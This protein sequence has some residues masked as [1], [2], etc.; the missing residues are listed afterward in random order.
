[1]PTNLTQLSFGAGG[2]GTGGGAAEPGALPPT[3]TSAQ[4]AAK[5]QRC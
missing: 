5:Y 3:Q 1:M 4:R 2:A